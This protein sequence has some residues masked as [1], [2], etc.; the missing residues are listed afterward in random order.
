MA[1]KLP[2]GTSHFEK[3]VLGA[4]TWVDKSLFIQEIIEDP[5][6]A[7]LITRPRRFGKP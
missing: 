6:E 1:L 7:I 5:S 3:M 4:Y 2:L